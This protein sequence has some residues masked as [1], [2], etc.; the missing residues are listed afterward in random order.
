L[1][2]TRATPL[3]KGPYVGLSPA[4][5]EGP[6]PADLVAAGLLHPHLANIALFDGVLWA[7]CNRIIRNRLIRFRP[8]SHS[9]RLPVGMDQEKLRMNFAE[10]SRPDEKVVVLEGVLKADTAFPFRDFVRAQEAASLVIDMTSV[11][12]MDSSGLGV[13]I[14]LYVSFEQSSRHL[15]LAGLNDRIWDLFRV[16][17]IEGVFTRYSTVA[18]AEHAVATEAR[19]GR[20]IVA[21]M[22]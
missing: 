8:S 17:K 7:A 5:R 16:C 15:L 1:E 6:L 2:A 22:E 3:L 18:E 9:D 21:F 11:R 19:A 13:L 10:G 14:G 20:N 12:S 4:S